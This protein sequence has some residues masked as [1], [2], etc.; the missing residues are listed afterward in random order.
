[1]G[2]IAQ[3]P[4]VSSLTILIASRH[5]TRL[6]FVGFALAVKLYLS[7]AI[8]KIQIDLEP[9]N[10]DYLFLG[11]GSLQVNYEALRSFQ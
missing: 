11:C 5:C 3:V 2:C 8:L 10:W 7:V 1:M 6:E 9:L 4:A